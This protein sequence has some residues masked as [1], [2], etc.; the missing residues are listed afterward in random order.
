LK[1]VFYS[2]LVGRAAFLI[3]QEFSRVVKTSA[4]CFRI[5]KGTDSKLVNCKISQCSCKYPQIGK[6]NA[7]TQIP[8]NV[9]EVTCQDWPS[10][11]DVG[12]EVTGKDSRSCDPNAPKESKQYLNSD[13]FVDAKDIY[14]CR[15]EPSIGEIIADVIN[16]IPGKVIHT[17]TD[18]VSIVLEIVK[19]GAI[20]VAGA[21]VFAVCNKMYKP[22]LK[23]FNNGDDNV[24]SDDVRSVYSDN[25]L[26]SSRDTLYKYDRGGTM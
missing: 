2:F 22:F 24:Y 21:E 15:A 1:G 5:Y 17:V 20:F 6:N 16:S 25:T 3:L 26:F 10:K 9:N 11:D 18:T 12:T 14:E 23:P 7:C 19:Y 4:G 13:N 8:K